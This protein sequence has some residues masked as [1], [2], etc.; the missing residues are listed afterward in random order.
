MEAEDFV[1]VPSFN[2]RSSSSPP[3]VIRNKG[4]FQTYFWSFFAFL[5]I[6]QFVINM[7][8]LV[9]YQS[10]RNQAQEVTFSK[11]EDDERSPKNFS[12]LCWITTYK[13]NLYT[14]AIHVKQTWAKRCDITIFISN[15]EGSIGVNQD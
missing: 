8:L 3:A 14:K 4:Y 15:H 2:R 10:H 5:A 13:D 1:F 6:M 11:V 7:Y 9:G 12:L